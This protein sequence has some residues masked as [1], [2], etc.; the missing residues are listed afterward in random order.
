MEAGEV[1]RSQDAASEAEEM[2]EEATNKV[3]MLSADLQSAQEAAATAAVKAH[4]AQLQ[5]SAHDQLM[6]NARQKAD[7]LSSQMVS[8]QADLASAQQ[9]FTLANSTKLLQHQ[10]SINDFPKISDSDD[11]IP[12]DISLDHSSPSRWRP[13]FG[14]Y[15]IKNYPYLYT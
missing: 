13:S 15:G 9:V 4:T 8:L 10:A 6:F 5:L 1:S 11:T 14:S 12:Q 7:A 2:L 3:R